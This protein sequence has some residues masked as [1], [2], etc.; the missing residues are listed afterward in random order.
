MNNIELLKSFLVKNQIDAVIHCAGL[1]SVTESVTESEKYYNSIVETTKNLLF[2]CKQAKIKNIMLSSSAVV[3]GDTKE[4]PI[5][6]NFE[7]SPKSPYA[8]YKALAE[9]L[10]KEYATD[11]IAK[12]IV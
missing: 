4:F 1:K 3:Y 11:K 6:E 12:A 5:L 10:F 9:N 8:K 2:C 7:V